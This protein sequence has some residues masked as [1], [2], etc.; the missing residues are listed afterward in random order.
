MSIHQ[1]VPRLYAELLNAAHYHFDPGSVLHFFAAATAGVVGLMIVRW[2]RGSRPSQLFAAFCL[3]FLLWVTGRGLSLMLSDPDLVL[4]LSRRL[5]VLITL[6]LPVLY[7]FTA[8]M[9]RLEKHRMNQIRLHWGMAIVV[10]LGS[11]STTAVISGVERY[12]WGYEPVFGV[13]GVASVFW[14]AIMMTTAG[15]DALRAWRA[16]PSDRAE[17]HRIELYAIAL[18]ILYLGFVEFLPGLGLGV[19][20]LGAAP[21]LAFTVMT[22]F[23]TY[24]YG[25]VEVTP[26][27]AAQEIADRVRGALLMLDREGVVQYANRRCATVLGVPEFRLLG[28]TARST[29]GDN[30]DPARLS[31]LARS[32]DR[33][34]E[35]EWTHLNPVTGQP[36][37]LAM[38]AFAVRDAHG[39]EVAYVCLMRDVTEKKHADFERRS[40]ILRDALTGLPNRTLFLSLLDRAIERRQ[41]DATQHYAVCFVGMHRLRVINEDLG[42]AAGDRVLAEAG[43][44]LRAEARPQDVVARVGGDEFAVLFRGVARR[45]DLQAYAEG[46]LRALRAPL[47]LDDHV[48][49]P[50]ATVGVAG[51]ERTYANGGDLLRDASIAMHRAKARPEG[52]ELIG[53][54]GIAGQRVRLEAELRAAIQEGQLT[55]FY[56][57]VIDL[58]RRAAAGFEALVRWQHPQRGLLRPD[59]FLPLAEDVGLIAVIDEFVLQR[60]CADLA[61][62]R[63]R[64]G[65]WS[66]SVS[67]NLSEAFLVQPGA[68]ERI[69]QAAARN[70]LEADDVCIELLER[71]VE[72]EPLQEVLRRLRGSGLRLAVDDFGTGHSALSRLHQAPLTAFKID[73][74]FVSAMSKGEGGEKLIGGILSL[75]RSLGLEAVAEGACTAAEVRRLAALGCRLVQGYFFAE[76]L[77]AERAQA[78]LLDDEVLPRRLRMLADRPAGP[79][80]APGLVVEAAPPAK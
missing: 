3:L 13:L 57:P 62:F 11:F 70:H 51:G 7:Q 75:A 74:A 61:E 58:G 15:L 20:P 47:Q 45:E 23:L 27:L 78:W 60:A 46:L 80:D 10:A 34:A 56:Q 12:P 25:L 65:D 6:A 9:L 68:V 53:A 79:P 24:R 14:V 63:R 18:A 28:R 2:E 64:T 44:R 55:V 43:R 39:R 50:S 35:K 17:H 1:D 21:I 72:L 22:A 4:F 29:L 77:P 5:Y 38:S 36:R 37:E 76:P 40:A 59:D 71:L 42:I 48:L 26:E 73:R 54:G 41:G 69:L 19:Y 31:A 32:A 8:V 33:D 30:L 66:L 16:S 52:V 49:H 67:I